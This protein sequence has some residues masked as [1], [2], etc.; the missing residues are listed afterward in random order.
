MP[1]RHVSST[2]P[3]SSTVPAARGSLGRCGCGAWRTSSLGPGASH[4]R[5][6]ASAFP[7]LVSTVA[8]RLAHC[9]SGIEQLSA[10]A[11]AALQQAADDTRPTLSATESL[12]DPAMDS[13]RGGRRVARTIC[14]LLASASSWPGVWVREEVLVFHRVPVR[15]LSVALVAFATALSLRAAAPPPPTLNDVLARAA[16]A[17]AAFADPSRRIICQENDRQTTV[18]DL[19]P[20]TMDCPGLRSPAVG[21]S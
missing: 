11:Q 8:D 16:A 2:E 20:I 15:L 18:V 9:L 10:H 19:V 7:P 12:T 5:R 3:T 6:L 13:L 17:T 14:S 4:S 21:L 1:G